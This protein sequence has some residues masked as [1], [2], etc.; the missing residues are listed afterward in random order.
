MDSY[1]P[2]NTPMFTLHPVE[3]GDHGRLRHAGSVHRNLGTGTRW[4]WPTPLMSSRKCWKQWGDLPA[5]L[6]AG[7]KLPMRRGQDPPAVMMGSMA[8]DCE[9]AVDEMRAAGQKVGLVR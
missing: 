7:R 8:E 3:A 5:V 1:L 2:S 9:A 4:P 6:R